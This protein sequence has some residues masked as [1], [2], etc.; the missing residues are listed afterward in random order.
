M[1]IVP[2]FLLFVLETGDLTEKDVRRRVGYR[3]C[4]TVA[5]DMHLP[6]PTEWVLTTQTHISNIRR[7][8]TQARNSGIELSTSIAT[9]FLELPD[10]DSV[11]EELRY[12]YI[13]YKFFKFPVIYSPSEFLLR[14]S[15]YYAMQD[16]Q[17]TLHGR[18][19]C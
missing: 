11:P 16:S 19:N 17:N 15:I 6:Y 8:I 18:S 13:H 7:V 9:R 14:V 10:P 12:M 3:I 5:R 2:L 4:K 1:K